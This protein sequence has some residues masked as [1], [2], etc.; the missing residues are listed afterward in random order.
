[1]NALAHGMCLVALAA[2]LGVATPTSSHPLAPA[3]LE[4]REHANG[5]ISVRFKTSVYAAR[6]VVKLRPSLPAHC[7]RVGRHYTGS[8]P[9][10]TVL[11]FP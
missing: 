3:L 8:T 4:L 7:A 10:G 11:R 5:S 6:G 1:M 2:A 9:T